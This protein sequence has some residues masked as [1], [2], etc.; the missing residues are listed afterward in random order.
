MLPEECSGVVAD[1]VFPTAVD[2]RDEHV[3][4]YYGMADACVG[5]ARMKLPSRG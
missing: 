2:Q 4:V 3:D 5:V 1:V